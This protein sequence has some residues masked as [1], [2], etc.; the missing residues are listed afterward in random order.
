MRRRNL[1]V[2]EQLANHRH[3]ASL[4]MAM[5]ARECRRSRTRKAGDVKSPLR[6]RA[7]VFSDQHGDLQG[8]Q[9]L[10][11]T[12]AK[13]T[14]AIAANGD[15]A[16]NGIVELDRHAKL[17]PLSERFLAHCAPIGPMS[18]SRQ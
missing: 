17:T 9:T 10:T 14:R 16:R 18:Q 15:A 13:F 8:D 3:D 11:D 6:L 12:E 5:P 1:G 7:R 2:S 4:D